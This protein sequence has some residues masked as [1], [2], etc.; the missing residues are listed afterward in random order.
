M[1]LVDRTCTE[2]RPAADDRRRPPD[3]RPLKEYR[4]GAAYVL[5]GDPGA[6]KTTAFATECKAHG[7]QVLRITA[8]DFTTFDP[9]DHPE[10]RDK[11]LFIDG[12]DEVRA[13]SSDART[14][15]DEIRRRLDK[16]GKPRF[17]LSCRAADW[18]GENDRKNLASVAPQNT[19]VAMLRLDPLTPADV[20]RILDHRTDAEGA[21]AFIGQAG[22]RGVEGLLENPQSLLLLADVVGI[23]EE[24]QDENWPASRRELFERA[25]LLLATEH[26]ED[27]NLAE[28]QPHPSDLVDA[29]GRLCA[30]SLTSG[31]AGFALSQARANG[32]Y[33]ELGDCQYDGCHLVRPALATGLFTAEPPSRFVPVHRHIAEFIGA[34]HLARVI[35]DGLPARRVISLLTGE[36]GVV[37][38]TLRGLSAWLAALCEDARL[39]LIRRDP[40]GVVSYGDVQGFSPGE[41]QNLLEALGREASRLNSVS[42]TAST[43]GAVATPGM[44]RQLQAILDSRNEQPPTLVAL[45]L[46]ALAH[47]EPL[48]SLADS[49]ICIVYG[50]N[51]W[52]QYPEMAL[53]A[54]IHNCRDRDVAQRK[55]EQLLVD[56]AADN[57]TDWQDQLTAVALSHLYPH[58][59]PPSKIW[60]HLTE[61]ANQ[62]AAE[63]RHFWRSDLA[64]NSSDAHVAQLLDELVTRSESLKSVLE[65]RH[66]K[67]VPVALL[68]RG[69][70]VWG[71]SLTTRRLF[72]WLHVDPFRS[73]HP[74]GEAYRRIRIWLEQRPEIQKEI[75]TEYVN[76]SPEMPMELNIRE[77]LYHSSPPADFGHWCLKQAADATDFRTADFY[78]TQ[79]C[80]SAAM[81][82]G[83]Q[84]VSIE[85]LVMGARTS[86]LLRGIWEKWRVHRL[87]ED[88]WSSY[89]RRQSY[90]QERESRRRSFV[91]L[92]RSEA[93]ALHDDRC[94][95]RLLHELSKAYLG[96]FSDVNGADAE[97]RMKEL[98]DDETPLVDAALAGMRG[99][100]FRE[101]VPEVEEIIGLLG[102][103]ED[104]LIALPVLVGID[105]LDDLRKLSDEQLRKAFAFHFCTFEENARIR[106]RRLLD[107]NATV[108]GEIL[109]QC[110][111]AK[112]RNGTYDSTIAYELGVGDYTPI[113]GQA[114]LPL[115]SAFPLRTAQRQA[116]AMLD[117][118]LIAALLRADRTAL[119]A[120]IA[121]KLSRVSMS[122]AQRVRWL[123]AEV[124]AAPNTCLNRLREF[125]A[126]QELRVS[127]L[128]AFLLRTGPQLDDLP[129]ATL[130][131]F[132][133]LLA[134]RVAPWNALETEGFVANQNE[135]AREGAADC[136][137][138]MIRT[139]ADRPDQDTSDALG[140]LAAEPALDEWRRSL[141]DAVDRQ[142]VIH[143]D[144]TYQH[145]SVEQVCRTLKA[146]TPANAGDL[147]ALLTDR[148]VELA[149]R[150][151]T[152][153]TDDWRQFWSEPPERDPTPKHEDHCRDALLSDLRQRLPAGVDAQPEGQYANDKRADIRVA[154]QDFEVSVEIKKN[155][156]RYLWS[157]ARNQL[158]AKYAS[159]PATGG[160]GIYLVF[161]FGKEHMPPPPTGAPPCG[162]EELRTR[163]EATLS[164]DERRKISVVVVDVQHM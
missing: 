10:W 73:M 14:P 93:N 3:S 35:G 90:T 84:G 163:L 151:R 87:S 61:S 24:G 39:E 41:K 66:L 25:G 161:W 76:G 96:L 67:D 48:P 33:V 79:S 139:L 150:I 50:E 28:P 123:A 95:P 36:D 112:M 136:V 7:D 81:Q 12:L 19:Q 116:I 153:N 131:T 49:L 120:L 34:K 21:R 145:P 86:E 29:A 149:R 141:Q 100:P 26:N 154:F 152:G 147:A 59:I 137:R 70:E 58:Q 46:V 98:F 40:I 109:V 16:L 88:H 44:E 121:G 106:A 101:D 23:G 72:D 144:A 1:S 92:V 63:Y 138:R 117:E 56:I 53:K 78:F 110:V 128:A 94:H 85:D 126:E 18:L 164:E 104:Y 111:S 102:S 115:L 9:D 11:T 42:W 55:L 127:Q 130:E 134:R 22:E 45:V 118:L 143:R 15:F 5:L 125:V 107:A 82:D 99:A 60:D 157:A 113:A 8:R 75:V 13:G 31:A 54:Y 105:E 124:V 6:G 30:I 160:Y 71:D 17:R 2:I 114:V 27:R 97:K 65:N 103:N 129:T 122:A 37:V 159:A 51:R 91:A 83:D 158:V 80:H 20:E 38:T 89:G 156:H 69:I 148:L 68:A 32:D 135:S 146:G 119:L 57:V 4:D 142:R 108:A 62:Y 133:D 162:S 140:R 132:V 74:S 43:L 155:R 64:A 52:A 47:G 77:L